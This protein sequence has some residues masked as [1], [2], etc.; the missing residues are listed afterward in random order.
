MSS[1]SSSSLS[2]S[3]LA[4]AAAA[5]VAPEA[6]AVGATCARIARCRRGVGRRLAR[7]AASRVREPFTER[8]SLSSRSRARAYQVSAPSDR[9]GCSRLAGAA[10][11]PTCG[12]AR[13]TALRNV[14][15]CSSLVPSA[16]AGMSNRSAATRNPYVYA[17][18]TDEEDLDK[19][20]GICG[21]VFEASPTGGA[22]YGELAKRIRTLLD[23]EMGVRGWNVVVGRSFGAYLTQRVGQRRPQRA[24]A[25]ARA[26]A[27]SSAIARAPSG[28]CSRGAHERAEV[29]QHS[30]RERVRWRARRRPAQT[31]CARLLRCCARR[32]WAVVP[33][34]L[35]GRPSHTL[36]AAADLAAYRRPFL[37]PPV[38][39]PLQEDQ[40]LRLHLRVPG[41]ERPRVA[42]LSG[43]GRVWACARTWRRRPVVAYPVARGAQRT[44]YGRLRARARARARVR[45]RAHAAAA[46]R[47]NGRASRR[48]SS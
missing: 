17:E 20:T 16:R 4:A 2:S 41:R 31:A 40:V 15:S 25:R 27:S 1:L 13:D 26:R 29:L 39:R 46:A 21:D 3:S 12:S 9:S 10:V 33:E 11:A 32:A 24:R 37:S 48:R 22:L 36:H 47:R 28:A 35:G 14:L 8:L 43:E 38:S 44:M 7:D 30:R 5:A 18:D 45:W 42:V 23:K 34:R 6:R 19:I